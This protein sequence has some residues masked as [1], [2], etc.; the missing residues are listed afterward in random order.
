MWSKHSRWIDPI[1]RSAKPLPRRDW[2]GRLVPNAHG[3]Q[4]ARVDGTIDAVPVADY[5][6]WSV[7]PRECFC[8]LARNPFGGRMWCDVDPEQLSAIQPDDEEGIELVETKGWDDEQ[9]HGGDVWRMVAQEDA[10]S[11]AGWPASLDHVFGDTRLRYLKPELEHL[12]VNAWC[13]PTVD[14]PCSSAGSVRA[15]P[16][17]FVAALPVDATSS[18][19]SSESP[20]C[21]DARA[22]R[23]G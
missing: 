21:A 10:P 16:P 7:I 15:A 8:Y 11:L 6:A 14:F 9:V 22:S 20:P 17:R 13:T 3:A 4:S 19:S 18:A 2:P 1:S 23:A 5:V 12:P